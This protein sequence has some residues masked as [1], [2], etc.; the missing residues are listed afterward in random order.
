MIRFLNGILLILLAGCA[1]TGSHTVASNSGR[2]T[3]H[4]SAPDALNVDFLSSQD[5]YRPH[6]LRRD[7]RG[8]WTIGGLADNEFRYFYVVDGSVHPPDCRYRETDDFGQVNCIHQ[9]DP[10]PN[11]PQT[12]NVQTRGKR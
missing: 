1:S 9:P 3:F 11:V 12:I 8:V 6:P 5:N 7:S 2:V 4:L 10:D